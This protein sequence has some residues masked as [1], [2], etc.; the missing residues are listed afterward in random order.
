MGKVQGPPSAGAPSSR[1]KKLTDLQILGCELHKNAFYGRA[2]PGPAG[3]PY[4]YPDFLA[5]IRGRE[6]LGIVGRGRGGKRRASERREGRDGK[7]E[8]GTGRGR[9]G[10]REGGSFRGK[11]SR[12]KFILRGPRV[13]SYATGHEQSSRSAF[14]SRMLQSQSLQPA[15]YQSHCVRRLM[16]RAVIAEPVHGLLM[17]ACRRRM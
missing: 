11:G 3:E 17:D 4:R 6:G 13:P 16:H 1:Q 2:A 14:M 7:G 9:E 15:V 10:K 8:G 12:E 5:V